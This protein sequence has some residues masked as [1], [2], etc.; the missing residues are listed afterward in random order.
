MKKKPTPRHIILCYRVQQYWKKIKYAIHLIYG[1]IKEKNL[2]S[3]RVWK[4]AA[5]SEARCQP[6]A[7]RGN[8]PPVRDSLSGEIIPQDWRRNGFSQVNEI[9]ECVC[10]HPAPVRKVKRSSHPGWCGSVDWALACKPKGRWFNSQS[11]HMPGLQARSPVGG[12]WEAATQWCF[13]FYLP[14]FPSLK[15]NK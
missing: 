13:P 9:R 2:I 4:N 11:G 10:Q 3:C 12:A 8:N 15:I 7:D 14:P 5:R 1:E 6:D